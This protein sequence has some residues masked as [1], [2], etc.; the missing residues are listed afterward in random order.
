MRILAQISA[1]F[2]IK[3]GKVE[4][5]PPDIRILRPG[6]LPLSISEPGVLPD[7]PAQNRTYPPH[8]RY[9][10]GIKPFHVALLLEKTGVIVKI[11]QWSHQHQYY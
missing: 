5:P 2:D 1:R 7:L 4:R 8:Q 6:F 10:N 9:N 11:P 3:V